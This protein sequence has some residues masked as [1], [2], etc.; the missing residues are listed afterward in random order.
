[1]RL[2]LQSHVRGE[3]QKPDSKIVGCKPA[4]LKRECREEDYDEDVPDRLE[5]S[6]ADRM[7][8]LFEE[9]EFSSGEEYDVENERYHV[10]PCCQRH[11]N[12]VQKACC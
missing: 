1:M 4:D 3:R 5:Y 8:F 2:L 12:C 6:H 10:Q 9:I 7:S 11:Y